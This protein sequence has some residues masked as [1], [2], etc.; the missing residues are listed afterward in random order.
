MELGGGLVG[1]RKPVAKFC[2]G[3]VAPHLVSIWSGLTGVVTGLV[4]IGGSEGTIGG[5]VG[6]VGVVL[7]IVSE[8]HD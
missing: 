2:C 3:D 4:D 5:V 1:E 7:S 6:T 8:A